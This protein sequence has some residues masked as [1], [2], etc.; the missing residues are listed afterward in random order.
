MT[1]D[2]ERVIHRAPLLRRM[3]FRAAAGEIVNCSFQPGIFNPACCR[4]ISRLT[5][6][7]SA[8]RPVRPRVPDGR[9]IA[10]D[11]ESRE[12]QQ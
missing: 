1:S 11:Y 8:S 5:R 12:R 10:D 3:K 9:R 7:C 6:A 4:Q 2:R